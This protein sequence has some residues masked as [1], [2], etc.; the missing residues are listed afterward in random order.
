MSISAK[1]NSP[2]FI[3]VG[4]R[5]WLVIQVMLA[6]HSEY[7]NARCAVIG[8]GDTGGLRRSSMC[9]EYVPLDIQ[10]EQDDDFI[11]LVEKINSVAPG[12]IIIPADCDAARVV[13][14]TR[15]MLTQRITP[16]PDPDTLETFDN[17]WRF[18]Q[19]ASKHRLLVPKTALFQRKTVLCFDDIV[20]E[21]GLPFVIKPVDQQGANGVHIVP[22]REYFEKEILK[23]ENYDYAPLIVQRYIPGTDMCLNLLAFNGD[24]RAF[25]IQ[26][27]IGRN[28]EQVEFVPNKSL[29]QAVFDLCA[30]SCYNGVMCLDVRLDDKTGEAYFIESNPRFWASH[31][32]SLWCGLNFVTA[33]LVAPVGP[34]QILT[35]GVY[36]TDRHPIVRPKV[37][38][39]ALLGRSVRGR[40]LNVKLFDMYLLSQFI[41]RHMRS[42]T[43]VY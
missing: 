31:T 15:H 11:R 8:G 23:N 17:K 41:K 30:A 34:C 14:R 36:E 6:I 5:A 9:S 3:V 2:N 37:W 38:L 19:F 42:N 16:I 22:S 4:N 18:Y 32:A 35:S 24:V 13:N 21:Y 20:S 1:Q 25:S 29:E 33:C 26:R 12:A 43:Q 28:G 40:I 7:N 10:G 27:R 39:S